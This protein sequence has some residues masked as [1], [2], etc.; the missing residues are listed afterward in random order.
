MIKNLGSAKWKRLL[1]KSLSV[2]LIGGVIT[3]GIVFSSYSESI[4]SGLSD[5]LIRLHVIANSDSDEDQQLKRDVRDIIIDYMKKN[6]GDLDN[7]DKAKSIISKNIDTIEE[8][9]IKEISRQ[10]KN[11]KVEANLGNYPFPTKVYGDVSLPAGNYQALRVVIGNG[12]GQ[13]WWC[14]LFPPLCF[15]D[16][17]HGTVPDSVKKDLRSVLSKEQYDIV[18]VNE[19]DDKGQYQ[20]AFAQTTLKIDKAADTNTNYKESNYTVST[21]DQD[22][23]ENDLE[24]KE[25][26]YE[27][28]EAFYDGNEYDNQQEYNKQIDYSY[29]NSAPDYEKA[30]E[31]YSS[32]QRSSN[33]TGMN[34]YTTDSNTKPQSVIYTEE[35]EVEI[36]IEIKFKVVEVFQDSKIKFKGMLNK[37]FKSVF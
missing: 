30:E 24:Y 22:K 16:A 1:V 35:D 4:N 10:N 17:T 15:V 21:I 28:N 7:V 14:V 33:K 3:C 11:Y 8:I 25:N 23:T 5:N 37:L 26:N 27:N 9:A 19:N 34:N 2:L 32:Y 13:N 31:T 12:E 20:P 36:P 6:F 29:Q 18:T